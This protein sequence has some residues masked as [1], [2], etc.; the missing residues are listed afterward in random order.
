MIAMQAPVEGGRDWATALSFGF[1][2][3]RDGNRRKPTWINIVVLGVLLPGFALWGLYRV[4][5]T[6]T[7]IGLWV[8][9]AALYLFTMFGVTLGNH[10]YWTH[11]GFKAGFPLQVVLA[12]ASGMAMEGDIQQWVMNHRAHHRFA[13]V[14]GKDPHSPYEYPEWRVYKGLLWAQGVW[15]FFSYERPSQYTLH[16]D[17][18][19]DR[20]VQWQRRAFPFLA[21]ANFLVPLAFY[22]LFGWNAVL[23]AGALRTAALMT[24]TGMVNSVCHKWGTRAKDSRGREFRADDSRNNPLVAVVAG[25]EGNHSWHHADPVCP[26]HGRKVELDADA[27]AAGAEPDHGWR[28]DATWRLIQLLA[29]LGLIYDVKQP[30]SR[31]YFA[32][33][34]LVPTPPLRQTHREWHIKEPTE[35]RE[36]IAA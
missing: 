30:K 19:E 27:A 14:V 2:V 35:V 4:F 8:L 32:D 15:L 36:L 6:P 26:R 12:V 29:G 13:D 25:G 28:P 23:I 31:L 11:R 33:K 16:R 34:Q 9:A 1:N 10:R 3:D 22:P 21:A 20:L 17:L 7:G 5:T 18:A 24:A